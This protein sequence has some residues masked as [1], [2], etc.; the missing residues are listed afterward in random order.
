MDAEHDVDSVEK[1]WKLAQRVKVAM[2]TLHDGEGLHARPMESIIPDDWEAIW[3][4]TDRHSPKVAEA[5]R[6]MDALLTYSTGARGDHLVMNGILAVVDDREKLRGLWNRGAEM[7]FPKGPKDPSVVL[8]R[9]EPIVAEYWKSGTSPVRFAL[10]YAKTK[11]TGA[12]AN[13]GDHGRVA[14]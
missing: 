8:L 11:L 1:V 5:S 6:R 13:L 9:F 2:L 4:I 3:F 14:L 10:Q 7:Y 12:P